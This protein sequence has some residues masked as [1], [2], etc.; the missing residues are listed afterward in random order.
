MRY[1]YLKI[2]TSSF[3]FLSILLFVNCKMKQKPLTIIEITDPERHYYPVP[4][5]DRLRISYE[6]KNKGEN[7]LEL[8]EIYT[9]CG[10]IIVDEKSNRSIPPHKSGYIY[11]EF[12]TN[13]NIG[14][15][16]HQLY[17][18]GNFSNK[19]K[20]IISFDLNVVPSSQN[21][22]DYEEIFVEMEKNDMFSEKPTLSDYYVDKAR[23]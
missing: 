5:G 19:E 15:V 11:F 6:I 2:I 23:N 21:I 16:S 12:D 8:S 18:Y 7:L 14:Y 22:K 10:C 20:Q 13:K 17:L 3:V 1:T 4:Q 9:S